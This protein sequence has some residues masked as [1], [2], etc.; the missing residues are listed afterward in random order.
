[1]IDKHKAIREVIK[2]FD[3][4][5][6]VRVMKFLGWTYR[7]EPETPTVEELKQMAV[8]YL[9]EIADGKSA[10]ILCGGFNYYYDEKDDILGMEF[11]L[12]SMTTEYIY[13]NLTAK[14]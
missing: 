4:D 11:T 9:N 6:V 2:Q 1:M 13:P 3:F 12:E 14:L 8:T 10:S 7:H 5:K